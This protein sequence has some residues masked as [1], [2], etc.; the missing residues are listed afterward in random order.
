MT[1][2]DMDEENENWQYPDFAD[3]SEPCHHDC[4]GTQ[5]DPELFPPGC[6][7]TC[8]CYDSWLG[9]EPLSDGHLWATWGGS[10]DLTTAG[11]YTLTVSVCND[12]PPTE[13]DECVNVN[14][15]DYPSWAFD[16]CTQ[17]TLTIEVTERS[18]LCTASLSDGEGCPGESLDLPLIILNL[19][20][21]TETYNWTIT[22]TGEPFSLIVAPDA[23][24]VTLGP[25]ETHAEWIQVT[26][27]TD[28]C[29]LG[30]GSQDATLTL[31][32]T[33]TEGTQCTTQDGTIRVLDFC[34]NCED[35]PGTESGW[36][37]VAVDRTRGCGPTDTWAEDPIVDDCGNSLQLSCTGAFHLTLNGVD[38]GTCIWIPPSGVNDFKYK[39]I[40][41]PCGWKISA[42][43]HR[44]QDTD[45]V[46]P[47]VRDCGTIGKYDWLD[48]IVDNCAGTTT[49]RCCAG[50]ADPGEDPEADCP[51]SGDCANVSTCWEP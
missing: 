27:P 42:T 24:S 32:V 50:D 48:T 14:D 7:C 12:C 15:P 8:I 26:I 21:C 5:N 41:T 46:L 35:C 37:D 13:P 10:V 36:L 23:G 19:G 25:S 34:S 31:T 45:K 17:K 3:Q 28:A 44:T 9:W 47:H 29:P 33:S 2:W 49:T 1:Y 30:A 16:E 38:V 11:T 43:F 39:K 4:L 18:R 20:D 51:S 22:Q 40:T 6:D